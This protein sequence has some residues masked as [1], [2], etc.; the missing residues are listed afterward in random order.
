MDKTRNKFKFGKDQQSSLDLMQTHIL[1]FV[2]KKLIEPMDTV[3]SEV[4]F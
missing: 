3:K 4:I 2:H 1:S